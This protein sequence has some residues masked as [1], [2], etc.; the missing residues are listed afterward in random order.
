MTYI[1][2][3]GAT[4]VLILLLA[5]FLNGRNMLLKENIIYI[6]MNIIG[7]GL[8]CIASVLLRYWPFIIL[9]ACWTLVSL[10]SLVKIIGK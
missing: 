3:I 7:A 2:I 4:G 10:F 6:L 9:E 1:D 5:Y 8:A